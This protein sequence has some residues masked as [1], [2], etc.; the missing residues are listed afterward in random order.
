MS[1]GGGECPAP[2]A[3]AAIAGAEREGETPLGGSLVVVVPCYN[4]QDTVGLFYRTIHG[5]AGSSLKA[6]GVALHLLFVDD[7]SSDETL[8]RLRELAQA[9]GDVS[10]VSFSRNFGKEAAMYAGLEHALGIG[11][12]LAVMDV[13]LQDPPSL[14]P[15]MLRRVASGECDRA[16]A[17]RVSR[18]GE[19]ALRSVFARLFYKV[20]SGMTG[21]DVKDGARDFSVMSRRFAQA[22]LECRE[23]NRFT[24][25]LF[26]W[27]GFR[28]EWVEFQN[29]ER[30]A[31]E[32]SWSFWS[33]AGYALEGIIAYTVKPLEL[34]V[35]VGLVFSALSILLMVV[36][37]VRA[38]LFGDRV[39]GWPSMMVVIL[40][41][42]GMITCALGVVG[43]YVSKIYTEVKGRPLYI[44]AELGGEVGEAGGD[45][46]ADGPAGA[47][48]GLA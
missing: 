3:P 31:G 45:A 20:M 37:F 5:A 16:A 21:L 22:V 1:P 19:P 43:L 38:L 10:Y 7:G 34:I 24:K 39:A 25:G 36:I 46:G 15:Q 29:V 6:M 27:V 8:G 2:A 26:E 40:L 44:L 13:D 11:D 9:H 47:G 42:V 32:T 14:L 17:R 4:E 28:V 18:K 33:L 30:A 23:Y 12:Y 48:V 35:A 41:G